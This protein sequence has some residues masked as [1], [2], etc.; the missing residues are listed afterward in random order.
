M[1]AACNEIE[2]TNCDFIQQTPETA[3]VKT[4]RRGRFTTRKS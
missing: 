4:P 1:I 3:G 2:I